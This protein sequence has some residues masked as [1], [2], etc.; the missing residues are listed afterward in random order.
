MSSIDLS[1]GRVYLGKCYYDVQ[2]NDV[3]HDS[4]PFSGNTCTHIFGEHVDVSAD[5]IVA[6]TSELNKRL[7]DAR[8]ANKYLVTVMTSDPNL[9]NDGVCDITNYIKL[10]R[11]LEIP[12]Y[13]RNDF[14]LYV[15]EIEN[16]ALLCQCDKS[17]NLMLMK[18][19]Y[20]CKYI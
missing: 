13:L 14:N 10:W 18:K 16:K 6:A 2:V 9:F 8:L 4:G 19:G 5:Q 1:S 3:I 17:K 15:S 11:F 12:K 20:A 7:D